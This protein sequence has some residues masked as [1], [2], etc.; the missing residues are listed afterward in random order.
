MGLNEFNLTLHQEEQ[1]LLGAEP[2]RRQGTP[3]AA[4]AGSGSTS[5]SPTLLRA[6]VLNPFVATTPTP[7]REQ[8]EDL[9]VMLKRAYEKPAASKT[10]SCTVTEGEVF[11]M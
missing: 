2:Q 4:A 1:R 8:S 5:P 7:S 3:V 9:V 11:T 10:M 6:P